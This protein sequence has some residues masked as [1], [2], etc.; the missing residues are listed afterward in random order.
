MPV[1]AEA[2]PGK[3]LGMLPRPTEEIDALEPSDSR[4]IWMGAGPVDLEVKAN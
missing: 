3:A 1:A 2:K 4:Q